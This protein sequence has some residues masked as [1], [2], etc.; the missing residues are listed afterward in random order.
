M[1][2]DESEHAGFT[3][4]KPW[5]G[6][7]PDYRQVNA[8]AQ[9][10]AIASVFQHYRRLIELRH[11]EPAVVYGDFRLLAP[12]DERVYAFTRRHADT[13]TELLVLANVSGDPAAFDVPDGWS[14]SETVI[15]NVARSASVGSRLIL[16]P[17]EARVHR[18]HLG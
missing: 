18:R 1:Q 8:A 6:V 12:D 7:N 15:T 9:R 16:A 10:T 13:G 11:T 17:W 5:I 2:W 4:G 3:S 14:G